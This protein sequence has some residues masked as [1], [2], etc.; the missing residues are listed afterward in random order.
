MGITGAMA[1]LHG[2]SKK[3]R[4]KQMLKM[5]VSKRPQ[6]APSHDARNR[7]VSTEGRGGTVQSIRDHQHSPK[8]GS[9]PKEDGSE[10]DAMKK[11][12]SGILSSMRGV[13]PFSHQAKRERLFDWNVGH[14]EADAATNA[15]VALSD[16]DDHA[17]LSHDDTNVP[18]E[19]PKVVPA[20]K[21]EKYPDKTTTGKLL[22]G[23]STE[24]EKELNK[25]AHR[26]PVDGMM[27]LTTFRSRRTMRHNPEAPPGFFNIGNSCYL[28]A[29]L[30]VLLNV[31]EFVNEISRLTTCMQQKQV[32]VGDY[33]LLHALY[34]IIQERKAPAQGTQDITS[35]KK[36]LEEHFPSVFAGSHQQDAHECFVRILEA[37][38]TESKRASESGAP[39]YECPFSFSVMVSMVCTMCRHKTHIE[40]AGN[41][42]IGLDL[43]EHTDQPIPIETLISKFFMNERISKNCDACKAKDVIH[44]VRRRIKTFPKALVLHL[45]R[46]VCSNHTVM[47][48]MVFSKSKVPVQPRREIP[49]SVLP[50][51]GG[52]KKMHAPS[53]TMLLSGIIHHH[54]PFMESGHYIADIIRNRKNREEFYRCNDASVEDVNPHDDVDH[55]LGRG[56]HD[57]YM[58]VYKIPQ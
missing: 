29:T 1:G 8:F 5:A 56:C 25:D 40:E 22:F 3:D 44:A 28:G 49:T 50:T 19:T 35:V 9:R 45:K 34:T 55:Y 51:S 21:Q 30:Q 48:R 32:H 2:V 57:C 14:E 31:C 36:A 53:P 38:E 27:T 17:A 43:G 26:P 13:A 24:K 33:A 15:T 54:G 39:V 6:S 47:N 46:F 16:E 23:S 7:G 11:R 18:V 10:V 37:I 4:G 58:L 20:I 42:N 52:L 41:V 12:K